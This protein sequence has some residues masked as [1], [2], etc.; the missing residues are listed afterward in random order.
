MI[1]QIIGIITHEILVSANEV[2]MDESKQPCGLEV[3]R[4][5]SP[6]EQL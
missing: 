4:L 5:V 1:A 3:K 2:S 6:V